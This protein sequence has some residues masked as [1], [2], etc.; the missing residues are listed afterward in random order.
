[1]KTLRLSLVLLLFCATA[2]AQQGEVSYSDDF[3]SYGSPRNPPGWVDTSIAGSTAIGLYKTWPD[4]VQANNLVYGT[5]QASG[6]PEG[7]H[8][9]IGTF[10]TLTA[11]T[12]SGN[13]RFE[14]RGRFLETNAD[15]HIGFTFFSSYPEQDAYYL[16]GT[17]TQPGTAKL[18]MQLF[19]FGAGT[20]AK[21]TDSNFA[22]DAGKW[23]RFLIQVDDA[24]G[25]TNVRARFWP[26]GTAEPSTFSIDATDAAPARLRQGR[27]GIWSAVKGDAFV[28]D[29]FAKSPV[30]H[31]APEIAFFENG[32]QL[33]VTG[34]TAL[35]HDAR[36]D[37]HAKDDLSG[38]ASIT[39]TADGNPY[40]PLTPIAA[41]GPHTIHARAVDYVGNASESEVKVL[42][43]K[44][45]PNVALTANGAPLPPV[46]KFNGVPSIGVA[47]TDTWTP[48]TQTV[49]LDGETYVPNTPVAKEGWH[50]LRVEA[51]DAVKNLRVAEAKILVDLGLPSIA[52]YEQGQKL[53]ATAAFKFN[54]AIEVRL[55]DAQSKVDYTATIDGNPW[56]SLD[57]I[58]ADGRYK[59]VVNAV[60]E[61]GNKAA[62]T[63]DVLVDK[64]APAV[65]LR[66]NGVVLDPA[67]RQTFAHDAKIEI[68]VADA[69]LKSDWSAKLNGAA[70]VSGDPITAEQNHTL[71]VHAAD[72][73]GN[74]TDVTLSFLIDKTLPAISFYAGDRL[75]DPRELHKFLADV[76]ITIKASD[77]LSTPVPT[78]TI[79]GAP[80]TSGALIADENEHTIVAT[81]VD[82]AGNRAEATLKILVDKTK[83]TIA[84]SVGGKPIDAPFKEDIR[85]DIAVNDNLPGVTYTSDYTSGQLI[86]AEGPRTINVHAVDR[87]G[88]T[89]DASVKILIDK[90]GPAIAFYDGETKL[91]AAKRQDFKRLPS[92]DVRVSD[93]FSTFTSS[94]T[95]D[96][97]Q[98]ISGTPIAE[99]DHT[100][101]VH[102]ADALGNATDAKLEL[103][104]DVTAPVVVLKEGDN[105]LPAADAIFARDLL[106]HAAVT[107]VSKTE[108]AATLDGQP[109]SLSVPISAEGPHTL[110]VTVTDELK[111]STTASARFTIDKT[112]PKITVLEGTTPLLQGAKFAR[113]AVVLNAAAE[114]ITHVTFAAKI[115]NAPYTLGQPF[116]VEGTHTIVV[117]AEDAAHNKSQVSILFHLQANAP[118]VRLLESGQ[119]FP[120]DK[121]LHRDQI[122]ATVEIVSATET[123]SVATID[124]QPYTL[125]T[126][127][128]AEGCHHI[129]IVVTNQVDL[130]TTVEADFGID[131]TPPAIKLF[132]APGTE[133]AAGMKF[134]ADL[135]PSTEASDNLCKPPK[136]VVLLDNQQ[137]PP[138][139]V[140]SEEKEH[141]IS[142]T[143]TDDAGLS[144]TV[145]PFTFV[146]DKT[147]PKVELLVDGKPLKDGDLFNK[148]IAV[149]I[150]VSDLTATTIDA[151]LNDS[152]YTSATNITADA[153]Y[154]LVVRVKDALQHETAIGPI[155][156]TV[157]KTAPD[158]QV[159]ESGQPF[160]G[161]KFKRN[162][163]PVVVIHDLSQTITNATLDGN[164]WSSGQE[165]SAEGTHTLEITVTDELQWTTVV[166]PIHFT[167][168]KA[169]PTVTITDGGVPLV[170]DSIFNRNVVPKIAVTALVDYTL[171]AKLDGQPFTS[172][173]VVGSEAVHTLAVKVTDELGFVRDV[174]PIVF[175][176]DKT[177]PVVTITEN[178][179]A[180]ADNALLD[181]NAVPHVAAADLTRV[182]ID[183][184]LDGQAYILGTP[185]TAEGPHTFEVSVTD[186]A[187]WK[188][189]PPPIHFVIDKTAP[190]VSVIVNGKPLAGGDEFGDT[191]A[192]Q[193]V[194]IDLSETMIDAKLDGQPWTSGSAIAA[195]GEHVLAVT[196]T[197]RAGW[198]TTLPPIAFVIDQSAP[199]VRVLEKGVPFAS[200][201]KFN[202][203]VEPKIVAD[204][205]TATTI[206]A[207]LDG[208]AWTPDSTISTES[209]Q[210]TLSITVTDHLGHP[211]AVPPIAF[212]IDKT[213]PVVAVTENGQPLVSGAAFNRNVRP[214]VAITDITQTT[215]SAQVNGQPY[216]FNTEISE[217]AK[218]T[219]T[220]TVTDE[221]NWTTTIPAI[222]FFVDK[223]APVVTLMEAEKELTSGTWFN[224]DVI[225]RAVIKDT[226]D[227][228]TSA[229]LNDQPYVLGT[230]ITAE[231]AYTLKVKVT[232]KVG[233]ATDVP[234]V[235]FTIDKTAPAIAFTN[236]LNTAKLTTPEVIIT[237]QADDAVTVDVNGIDT[238]VAD[239]TFV[240]P[241]PITLL[242]GENV[243][244]ANGV[245][246]AGNTGTAGITVFLDTRAPDVSI[247]AP[248]ANAC[249][250]VAEVAV[251]GDVNDTALERVRVS[252]GTTSVDAA[253][254]ADRHSFTASIPAPEGKQ[255]IR[256]EAIDTGGHVTAAAV[257]VTIDRTKPVVEITESG[258][259][260]TAAAINRAV[261]LLMR[262]NEPG[263]VLTATLD[264][265]PYVSGTAIAAEGAH[266][267]KASAKDCAGHVSD[268][269]V[270]RFVIDRT[271]PQ[272]A[273]IAP[274]NGATVRAQTAI[275]GALS[276]PAAVVL[277]GTDVAAAVNGVNFTLNAPLREGANAFVLR[278]SDAAGNVSL[279]PY[280][281]RL[282]STAPSIEIVIDD[283]PIPANAVYTRAVAPVV[284]SN[285]AGAT[286][287]AT[288]NGQPFASGT[289]ISS[290]GSYTLAAKAQDA[291]GNESATVTA[292]F[293]IDRS[294]PVVKIASPASGAV[295][296]ADSVEVRGTAT[297]GDVR[298]VT[299][300]GLAATLA[301]DGAFS[302]RAALDL[303]PNVLA[304]IATDAA[305]NTS[306]DSVDVV[307]ASGTTGLIL[308][309]PPDRMVT[310]RPTT[311]VAGQLLTPSASRSVTINGAAVPV[312]AAGVFRKTDFALTE[313]ANTITATAGATSVA[314]VV[315]AD[316]AAGAEGDGERQRARR[317]RALR[318][319]ACDC[320]R[321]RER[322]HRE[323]DH[324][325]RRESARRH[326]ARGW[327]P[328]PHRHRARRGRQRGPPRP[329]LL[330]RQRR[331]R[332]RL[333][334]LELRSAGRQRRLHRDGA[335]QRTLRRR[336]EHVDQRPRRVGF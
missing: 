164:P 302:A 27:I 105:V 308:T 81:A 63:L 78:A 162:L 149:E 254:S 6:Q 296:N 108:T 211:T 16:L 62:A 33:P 238:T 141:T 163:T 251:A 5:K 198:K 192:P 15:T 45:P 195:E 271:S 7:N 13:G 335:H 8:P 124:G 144:T 311:V 241:G 110:V 239:K 187:N 242:E 292:A 111:W 200:G 85:V 305:G 310:N 257:T 312:D 261:A 156:F 42:V 151:K 147:G 159:L 231:G 313:G 248:K 297:G 232:D 336:R 273:G 174:P 48:T 36:V 100:I 26:D 79:D 304:A 298:S 75:L 184:R 154:A 267:I 327:R 332:L 140:V 87:A 152:G 188:T 97:I 197:D 266:E 228:T 11:K 69:N 25:A 120:A 309:A 224:R 226:T 194:V 35:D 66:E 240:T 161:G 210:H 233:L 318:G 38:V 263:A 60:D 218:Y 43:D 73:A 171:D 59:I 177:P 123:A 18:T 329:R 95:I 115:D 131:R 214:Q 107:D 193:I 246:R 3:Q 234:A 142:A 17:W 315:T 41:E 91:D 121:T 90:S 222:V 208:A 316:F 117:D 160:S 279:V 293:R 253:I 37:V 260:F 150:R 264:G 262:T 294:G 268:E 326:R 245:D 182:T 128:A 270:Q 206:A 67:K 322:R 269:A 307:R 275:T 170:T 301:G 328:R 71:V 139:S 82:D 235:T 215:T 323:A 236:P 185:V 153:R 51:V 265:Q 46:A 101:G 258:T 244:T 173:T 53:G 83:P 80:Y 190:I 196:V 317:R 319:F 103:L 89:A 12:F 58:T 94:I 303:G 113:S 122:V 243:L 50:Y 114:D 179:A 157:D 237:G 47:V 155:H 22:P 64:I 209:A 259:R 65:V 325:R 29:L 99:G 134:D 24:N 324:R 32:V 2:F 68:S 133:F 74:V 145:G 247:N 250:D 54:P 183:A 19:A 272:L 106:V 57:P 178:G 277:D 21:T 28:D 127:Y 146:L 201:T 300:N 130:S 306:V 49:T 203:D 230:P 288:L 165:I 116:A 320:A 56:K 207:T 225:P 30:D 175:T 278:L 283:A 125:G 219:L 169:A 176:V 285:D 4:P 132:A 136:V 119:P 77:A 223:T 213:A 220:A 180:F 280:N 126:P 290:D 249:L 291:S 92:I 86:S 129:K 189:A 72:E 93:A 229:T 295:I 1:M 282:D 186:A 256:V 137:L 289:S 44:T 9:R 205:L 217:E 216:T 40:T 20:L 227:T 166:P 138:G 14:Y 167:I 330:R 55:T 158:V 299:V 10:S 104:V 70:Y 61:A 276:E 118:E 112:A 96:G 202:R 286:V 191:I 39:A 135:T 172:E 221:L 181:H 212:T 88:N 199:A 331:L 148:D 287:T 284:R 255:T 23:Y 109:F 321:E 274:A 84:F 52:F 76:A 102:A 334:A 168:A 252:I 31:L 314:V 333:R 34:V 281:V 204:D 98:Y 143:A